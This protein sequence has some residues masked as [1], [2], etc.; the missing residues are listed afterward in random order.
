MIRRRL[1]LLAIA[2]AAALACS[3]SDSPTGGNN[4]NGNGNN[5]GYNNATGTM[6]ATVDGA[7]W[8]ANFLTR[9]T[10]SGTLS[11]TGES[12]NGN[13]AQT[14]VVTMAVINVTVDSTYTLYSPGDGHGGNAIMTLGGTNQWYTSSPGGSGT[15]TVTALDGT[16]V[17]GTFTFVGVG[18]GSLGNSTVTNGHFD[19]PFKQ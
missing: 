12:F 5:N 6:T 11:I 1:L 9:A 7:S 10:Y 8:T 13:N 14:R 19:I 17:A 18:S 2:A 3:S 15:V 4:D 16:H